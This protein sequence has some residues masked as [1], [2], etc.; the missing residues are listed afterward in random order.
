MSIQNSDV[1][2]VKLT[3]NCEVRWDKETKEGRELIEVD[4]LCHIWYKLVLSIVANFSCYTN[5]SFG[6]HHCS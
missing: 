2:H 4:V 3:R 5:N 6:R 1:P